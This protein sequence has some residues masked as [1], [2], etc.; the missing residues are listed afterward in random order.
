MFYRTF[1]TTTCF[2]LPI[3]VNSS[4]VSEGINI[5]LNTPST[6]ITIGDYLY[7]TTNNEVR[8]IT[9]VISSTQYT[10]E[11]AFTSDVVEY[12]TVYIVDQTINY[13][14]VDIINFG[15]ASGLLNGEEFPMNLIANM[16]R[17]TESIVF[18]IDG[19][20]TKFGILALV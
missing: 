8:K 12:A 6:S 13:S 16:K 17:E 15:Y 3:S 14:E 11:T 2:P 9:E 7:T 10:I 5:T 4:F 1:T 19:T 18:T 20:G